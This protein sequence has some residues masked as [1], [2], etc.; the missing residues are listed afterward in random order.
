MTKRFATLLSRQ[1][2]QSSK[3]G[4]I[5]FEDAQQMLKIAKT[6]FICE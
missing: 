5:Y 6:E 1:M 4:Q 3:E 2:A